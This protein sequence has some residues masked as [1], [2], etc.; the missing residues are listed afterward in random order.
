MDL[1][2]L[3]EHGEAFLFKFLKVLGCKHTHE[4]IVSVIA[5]HTSHLLHMAAQNRL[6]I[7]CGIR[8]QLL[9]ILHQL[10]E[11][12]DHRVSDERFLVV[13][14]RIQLFDLG[15]IFKNGDIKCFAFRHDAIT[16]SHKNLCVVIG[17]LTCGNKGNLRSVVI[18]LDNSLNRGV[19]NIVD[20]LPVQDAARLEFGRKRRIVPHD[21]SFF[22]ANQN[23]EIQLL[24]EIKG[25]RAEYRAF[26]LRKIPGDHSSA[27]KAYHSSEHHRAAVAA[28][29][30]YH[31]IGRFI[32]RVNDE[33]HAYR[34][35]D[36][37][38]SGTYNRADRN[39]MTFDFI[40]LLRHGNPSL[41]V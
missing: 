1:A 40:V 35:R 29:R 27:D 22:V 16:L 9:H 38:E 34:K 37:S 21:F 24:D 36:E 19:A 8:I 26:Y 33:D 32:V 41:P 4:F 3:V 23:R 30:A 39:G 17:N 5:Q 28:E 12:V 13:E 31:D 18:A 14:L 25:N 2:D 6:H 11:I 15:D 10:V 20:I 7:A